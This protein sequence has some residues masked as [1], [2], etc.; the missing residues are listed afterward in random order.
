VQYRPAT[1]GDRDHGTAGICGI[2][3]ADVAFHKKAGIAVADMV[4]S[5]WVYRRLRNFRAGIEAGF[6]CLKRAYDAAR[7]TWRASASPSASSCQISLTRTAPN[8]I[9][10]VVAATITREHRVRRRLCPF[11]AGEQHQV[12]RHHCRPDVGLEV[13]EPGWPGEVRKS[14]VAYLSKDRSRPCARRCI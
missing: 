7:C 12:V 10:L 3:V 2:G 8:A 4:K 1:L 5:S 9:L 13:A 6:S 14:T 11:E